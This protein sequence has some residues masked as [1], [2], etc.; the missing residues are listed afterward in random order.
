[1]K[2]YVR[3]LLTVFIALMLL[4]AFRPATA[5]AK[6]ITVVSKAVHKSYSNGKLSSE[7]T[8]TYSYNKKGL[9]A[10]KRTYNTDYYGSIAGGSYSDTKY[11]YNKANKL[12]KITETNA[13]TGYKNVF[14]ISYRKNGHIKSTVRKETNGAS[15]TY[16][17]YYKSGAKTPY[18]AVC[19][20]PDLYSDR[21]TTISYTYD[22]VLGIVKATET[23]IATESPIN[24]PSW[25][26]NR[27]YYT[28]GTLAGFAKSGLDY[29]TLFECKYSTY[30]KGLYITCTE[31]RGAAGKI[32][33]TYTLKN[34]EVK[35]SL[36][37][38]IQKQQYCI[39]GGLSMPGY[40]GM[41]Y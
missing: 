1:M 25:E 6:K 12:I 18:K 40:Y 38:Y 5:E 15:S 17:Y 7:N 21:I 26:Y 4:V 27:V 29:H 16:K 28:S 23:D 32:Y 19:I 11:N 10:K 30:K 34:I 37:D 2:K 22:S 8:V 13:G 31:N 14:K 24:A 41:I 36:A 33:S 39:R 9:L 20:E 3:S 35:N